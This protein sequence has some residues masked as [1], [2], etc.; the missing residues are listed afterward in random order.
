MGWLYAL[1]SYRWLGLETMKN[2]IAALTFIIGLSFGGQAMAQG[3]LQPG[4]VWGNP[5]SSQAFPQGTFV[6]PLL[7]QEYSCTAQG[8]IVYRGGTLWACLAP[9]ASGLPLLSQGA[10]A[11]LHY[12]LLPLASIAAGTSDTLLGY[13]GSTAVT[14]LAI[15]NCSNALTYNTST[16]EFG[17]NTLAGTGTVTTF[18]IVGSDGITVVGTCTITATGTCTIESNNSMGANKYQVLTATS[19][20]LTTPTGANWA[21]FTLVGGGAGGTGGGTSPGTP[22]NGGGNTCLN[23]SGAACTS[24]IYQ[25]GGGGVGSFSTGSGGAGGAVSGSGTC[26]LSIAGGQ[27]S[28]VYVAPS[29]SPSSGG[30]GGQST[31]GGAG[32]ASYGNSV[33]SNGATNSGSG[34]QAGGAAS[35]S[36]LGGAGGGAGATCIVLVQSPASTYTYAVGTAGIGGNGG[37]GGSTGGNG[38]SGILIAEF[39][40][41]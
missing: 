16:H 39:G 28:P 6:G 38:G 36:G 29:G 40:F 33:G 41:N 11:N 24:P 23:T 27:G 20:T 17:C 31:L 26:S 22:S 3:Q 4:Q 37:T 19:G 18:T 7:D 25:A 13:W 9:G 34:G 15:N 10:G 21:K 12:A 14:A 2:L 5:G 35:G 32:A 30:A 1:S 8:S